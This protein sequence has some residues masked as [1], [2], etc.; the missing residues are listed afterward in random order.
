LNFLT[1]ERY[2]SAEREKLSLYKQFNNDIKILIKVTQALHKSF[3]LQEIC[4]VAL[5]SAMELDNVDIAMIYLVDEEKREAVLEA[6]K[7]LPEDYI[8]KAGRIPYSKG[9]TWK[10]INSGKI[11]NIE[12][13]QK[14]PDL[15]LAGRDLGHHSVLGIPIFLE[16]KI[17]GLTWF[18]SYK[19][20]K[21]NEREIKLLSTLG[22]QIAIA[23][24]KARMFEEMKQRQEALRESEVRYENLFDNVP[25]GVYRTTPDGRIVMANPAL[26]R[27]LGYSSFEELASRNLEREGFDVNYPRS[28]FK[29]LLDQEGE[30]SGLESAWV[31]HDGSVVFVLE[32][33]RVV[34]EEDGS[35]LYYEGTVEDIT[36]RKL[37]EEALRESYAQLAKKNRYETIISSVTQSVH[38]S[39]NLQ[40]VLENAVQAMGKNIDRAD[41]VGIYL[42][43]GE[44][45]V[46]RAYKGLTDRYIERAGRIPYPKGLTWKTI[47]E[48]NPIYCAD[49]E[50]DT[51][52]GLAGRELGIKSY[53][54]MP[55]RYEGKTVGSTGIN[56][57][58]KNAFNEEELKLLEIV[59]EQIETAI[60][61]AKQVKALRK[62]EEELRKARDELE[63]RVQERTA[64]LASANKA[65]REN[66]E[67]FRNLV[68]QTN[69]WIWEVDKNGIFTYSSPKVQDIIGYEP[70][71]TLGKTT[72]D[73]MSA[74]EAKRFGEVIGSYI[75]QEKPFVCVEKVLIHR[76]VRQIIIE[77]SGSLVFDSHGVLQG[78]RGISRDI[79]ERKLAEEIIK[80]SEARYRAIVE[81]Q[82]EMICRF[83][84]DGML[85]FVNEAYCRYFDKKREEL[86]GQSF[87]HFI[88]DED[89]KLL[90][91]QL[92]SISKEN[93][94]ASIEHRVINP[95]GEIR[96]QQ[97][98][99]RALFDEYGRITEF[100]SVGWDTTERRLAEEALQN[101]KEELE[102]RV[103]ERTQEL[104]N[105]NEELK[106]EIA[107]RKRAE[108]LL[109]E[110]EERYRTLVE[111]SYDLIAE[112]S[113]D[114]RFLY[115]SSK[116][117]V[118]LGYE[119]KELLGTR[120][121]EY[122]HPDDCP[123]AMAEFE[124]AIRTQTS[125]RAVFRFRHKNRGWRWLESTDKPFRNAKGQIIG[126]IASRDIT[127]RKHAE[128]QIKET[129]KEKEVLLKEIHHRVKNNLQVISSLI[130]LQSQY[131]KSKKAIE[132]FNET[133]NRIRSMALIHEQLYQSRNLAMISFKEYVQNLLS[134]LLYS[135]EIDQDAIQLNINI[136]DVSMA[137]DTAFPCGLIINELISNSLKYA[138]PR[139]RK[140]KILIGLQSKNGNGDPISSRI[141]SETRL[142]HRTIPV[143][144]GDEVSVETLGH[145]HFTLIVSDNG[146]GFPKDLDFRNTE[147]LGLQ[148]V[149]ELAEQLRGSI[150]LDRKGGTSFKIKFEE[151]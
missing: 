138:F 135:Y 46:L 151:L 22:D 49:A 57:F 118:V 52:I 20:R 40:D 136:E 92:A 35:V 28:Q 76:N 130:N 90:E 65:L 43:E 83:L 29:K 93:P 123:D 115:V 102:L 144:A 126:V 108:V 80:Q 58:E 148:L 3:N 77:T 70:G 127:E 105:I 109:A 47:L 54:S 137:I 24:A 142:S 23:I 62:S 95:D 41:I 50:N 82:T 72:F 13:I 75:S 63:L 111:H 31:K 124:R 26:V 79:T 64:E 145:S 59:V 132:M 2:N 60:N 147:S 66:E 84:S 15:G 106:N 112:T 48:G 143:E 94:M 33:T 122:I 69:D 99:D 89:K 103:Q 11:F 139:G 121:F 96:W 97:W 10:A 120:V 55:I 107:E 36:N 71:E 1:R 128:E 140:G 116:H 17:I 113:V 12:D 51:F 37:A 25:T 74:D 39:I 45:A 81:D 16:E 38:Q 78:Y 56:S 67:K 146:V 133:Q 68:E 5:D 27:M 141:S 98:T 44:E 8:K 9:V 101:A 42:V 53:L 100:Q 34:C 21:F 119:P 104:S 150:E 18:L 30:I 14:D 110:S 87:M 86:I 4:K 73:F 61:N 19:E 125:G 134:N 114:G 88:P 131:I 149:V 32:S 117:K 6:H 7:N 85:T 91:K 129:L